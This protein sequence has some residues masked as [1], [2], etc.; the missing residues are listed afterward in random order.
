MEK[1]GNMENR[2]LQHSLAVA[3]VRRK[4]LRFAPLLPWLEEYRPLSQAGEKRL[5]RLKRDFSLDPP[6]G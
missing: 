1:N 3:R 4:S 6:R 2:A 5:R